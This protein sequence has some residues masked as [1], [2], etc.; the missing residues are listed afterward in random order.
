[1]EQVQWKL[2]EYL[3]AHNISTLHL[4]H[5]A[6]TVSRPTLYRIVSP[7]SEKRPARLDFPTLTAIIRG[8][9]LITGK[10][11]IVSDVL[12]YEFKY[13]VT[14]SGEPARLDPKPARGGPKKAK[15]SDE[16]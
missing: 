1:M 3:Q 4:E 15:S 10:K 6:G 13:E 12:E 8:L 7:D 16:Q 11:V 2:R 14:P 5:A 9:R